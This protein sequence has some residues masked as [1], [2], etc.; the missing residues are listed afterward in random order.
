MQT[1]R[2]TDAVSISWLKKIHICPITT[3]EFTVSWIFS[4]ICNW[5]FLGSASAI[6]L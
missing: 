6:P 5:E 1:T 3:L 4:H 2:F